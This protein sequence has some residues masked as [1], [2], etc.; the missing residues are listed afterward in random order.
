MNGIDNLYVGMYHSFEG[1]TT[2]NLCQFVKYP[3]CIHERIFT[4][5]FESL[6]SKLSGS[7]CSTVWKIENF[8]AKEILCEITNSDLNQKPH[9]PSFRTN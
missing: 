9:R 5:H 2:K 7:T 1:K 4:I 6:C 8:S 3:K